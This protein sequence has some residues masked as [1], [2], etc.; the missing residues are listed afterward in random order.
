MGTILA[1]K[2]TTKDKKELHLLYKTMPQLSP[3]RT[4]HIVNAGFF[5][6]ENSVYQWVIPRIENL[7]KSHD[8][9]ILPVPKY[10]AGMNDDKNDYLL[11]EDLRFQGYKM[12]DK[13]LGM[14]L[15][16]VSLLMKTIADFHASTYCYIKREGEK[17]FKTEEMKS[18]VNTFYLNDD[19]QRM[20]R[21]RLIV[22]FNFYNV[23]TLLEENK[24]GD[25]AEKL[26]LH[27]TDEGL[28][29]V[30]Q[31]SQLAT[32]NLHF[33]C[34][35][36][37]DLWVN[38]VL[39]RYENEN[40]ERPL[41]LKLIDFQSSRRS[42][43]Y[44]DLGYFFLSSTTRE[45]R[46]LHLATALFTYYEAFVK[47][48]EVLKCPIP[49]NFTRGM[50]I[51]HYFGHLLSSY[52][53]LSFALPLHLA[54]PTDISAMNVGENCNGQTS[55]QSKSNILNGNLTKPNGEVFDKEKNGIYNQSQFLLK[56]MRNS[57]RAVHRLI[58]MTKELALL[59]I[60]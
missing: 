11:L 58:E 25:L 57:P 24:H 45:F 41:D 36:H 18:L 22:K 16:E 20:R 54:E 27:A 6:N 34:I 50:F 29:R 15:P 10:Y 1:I 46:E 48:V 21:K 43:I 47:K 14:N 42:N 7:L 33:P 55:P 39:Y 19:P 60:L 49:A 52:L 28:Q 2:V 53:V 37:G 35:I 40:R 31:E 23:I 3:E 4:Q 5:R 59:K 38:N 17:I 56:Q 13:Y 26:R 51:D 44:E 32:D 8:K 9:S 12:P 30:E